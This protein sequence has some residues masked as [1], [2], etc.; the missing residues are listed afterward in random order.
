MLGA[1]PSPAGGGLD[2]RGHGHMKH[3]DSEML[4]GVALLELDAHIHT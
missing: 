2:D 1:V 4:S 3:K